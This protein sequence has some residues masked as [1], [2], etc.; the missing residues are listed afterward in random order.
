MPF[1][2]CRINIFAVSLILAVSVSGCD[3]ITSIKEYFQGSAKETTDGPAPAQTTAP[4]QSPSKPAAAP[5]A[6][7]TLAR[8]GDW[9]MTI[10][11]FNERLA[12]LKEA[13]PEYDTGDP[14]ARRL[15]LDE[16]VN[17]QLL[18]MGAQRSGLAA[19]K[20]IRDA[21]EEFRRTLIV[22]EVARQ[23]TEN[24]AMTE[25][26]A[27]AFYDEN[28]EAMVGP[29]Q[30]HVREIVVPEKED[31]TN[32]LMEILQGADFAETAKLYSA[33][34]TAAEGGDLGF[35]TQEPFP[36]MGSALLPLEE[37]DVS[38]VFKGPEGYYIVKLEEKKGGEQIGFDDI[39]D[40]IIQS[41][42]LLKQQQAVLDHLDRLK[43]QMKIEINEQLLE[44]DHE[45]GE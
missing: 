5:M 15:I 22:R 11:E 42:T 23:L 6:A 17:Q 32:I 29:A 28:K 1:K 24:I 10:E 13:V 16:L 7:N 37:G 39:K 30:W 34:K 9:S 20:D 26:E 3:L 4:A 38:S 21:V 40:D 44:D 14:Q 35:I 2:N 33:G 43:A 8:I 36:Q 31:A 18:V 27:R 41:Q 12:A 45:P 25:E 19:Q